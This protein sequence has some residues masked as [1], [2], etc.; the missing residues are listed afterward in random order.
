MPWNLN[1]LKV[2]ALSMTVPATAALFGPVHRV[3]PHSVTP[4][5]AGFRALV[6]LFLLAYI[7]RCAAAVH[8]TGRSVEPLPDWTFVLGPV[9]LLS[10]ASVVI[11]IF[12][13]VHQAL[14][15]ACS[16]PADAA[17]CALMLGLGEPLS[18][19]AASALA[20]WQALAFLYGWTDLQA[21]R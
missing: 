12:R 6:A 8:A 4:R 3:L 1:A 9:V 21:R 10:V 11:A 19:A 7:A 17:A 2:C 20:I 15:M 14:A 5:S 13:P 18:A 16:I